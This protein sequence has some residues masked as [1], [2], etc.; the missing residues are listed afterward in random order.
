M[1][2]D[3]RE[4]AESLKAGVSPSLVALIFNIPLGVAEG[5]LKKNLIPQV[6]IK[7]KPFYNF[8]EVFQLFGQKDEE[9][10]EAFLQSAKAS[11]LPVKLTEGYWRAKTSEVKYRLLAGEAWKTAK[12]V[13]ALTALIKIAVDCVGGSAEGLVS[14]LGL[15]GEQ[16]Q[17]CD[18]FLQ[19]LASQIGARSSA[20]LEDFKLRDILEE[21][22]ETESEVR[23]ERYKEK[24][25][26]AFEL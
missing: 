6:I 3:D 5:M 8:I 2:L 17:V 10:I 4:I 14:R 24:R 19:E 13:D 25:A 26:D 16:A 23:A 9:A 7:R 15:R 1:R 18:K 21:E 11:S 12:L 22:R 20:E